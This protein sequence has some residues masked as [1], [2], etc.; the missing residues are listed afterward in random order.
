MVAAHITNID[1]NDEAHPVT[2]EDTIIINDTEKTDPLQTVDTNNI[3]DNDEPHPVTTED[4]I[5]IN[6]IDTTD[7]LATVDIINTPD[8]VQTPETDPPSNHPHQTIGHTTKEADDKATSTSSLA[9][10]S[11]RLFVLKANNN[12]Q[13]L[14]AWNGLG[15][16]EN[17]AHFNQERRHQTSPCANTHAPFDRGR[18][19]QR[20]PT[21]PT[22]TVEL[23]TPFD[24][25]RKGYYTN[26]TTVNKRGPKQKA[27]TWCT[28]ML[29]VT[30]AIL[31]YAT[32]FIYPFSTHDSLNAASCLPRNYPLNCQHQRTCV[33]RLAI[34]RALF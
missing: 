26:T 14:H 5:I 2:T 31:I 10:C 13:H 22:V 29:F 20:V 3:T 8:N 17:H 11:N 7:P 16:T 32:A 34:C 24:R 25:G 27:T 23:Q 4:I 28:A 1:D 9:R 18:Q 21:V 33:P 12:N 6:D 30:Y 15:A 19:Q